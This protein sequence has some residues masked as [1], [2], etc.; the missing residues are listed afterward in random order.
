[1]KIKLNIDKKVFNDV[2]YPYLF[3]YSHKYEIWYGGSGSG[4]SYFIA[5]KILIKAL[6]SKRRVLVVRKT[7]VS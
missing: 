3:D 4:K 6:N 7:M 1:M 5:Q 2:Y